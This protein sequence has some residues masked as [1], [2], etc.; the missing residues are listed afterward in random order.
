[1]IGSLRTIQIHDNKRVRT[2]GV[3]TPPTG[4]NAH[5]TLTG[6]SNGS[7]NVEKTATVTSKDS[8]GTAIPDGNDNFLVTATRPDGS[9]LTTATTKDN[10]DGTY[11]F[12]FTPNVTGVWTIQCKLDG[13]DINGSPATI[14]YS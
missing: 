10:G 7:Y 9:V 12:T 11:T 3:L 13:A 14:T 2:T 4:N 8:S 5:S 6:L 1:L